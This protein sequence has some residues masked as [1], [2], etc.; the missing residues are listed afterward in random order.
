MRSS[1]II[2]LAIILIHQPCYSQT[3][4]RITDVDFHLDESYIVVDYNITGTLPKEEMTIELKFVSENN[5][6]INPNPI[7]ISGDIGTK[8]CTDGKKQILWNVVGDA[9]AFSG[10]FKAVVSII[11]SKILYHGASNALLSFII[12]GL[13][14]YFVDKSKAR[15]VLT[16]LSATGALGYS[17]FEYFQKENYYK[18][19]KD[20]KIPSELEDLYT[21]ANTANRNY[22]LSLQV[23]LGIMA[24]DIIYVTIKGA[25]NKNVAKSAYNAFSGD[26]LKINY[27]SNG[28]QV[29]YSVSF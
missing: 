23:G 3:K 6:T 9:I 1:I 11:S 4:A 20:S 28:L 19:Y 27:V 7:N 26:G 13:G 2:F 17:L 12:P 22:L 29:G 15:A 8:I 21:K 24:L 25:H 5:E 18:K 16:T 10:S 14:G